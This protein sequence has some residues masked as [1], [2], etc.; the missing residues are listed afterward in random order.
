M[1]GPW[2][3]MMV[4]RRIWSLPSEK[5]RS[6]EKQ[7]SKSWT[8]EDV[9]EMREQSALGVYN[10]REP[11]ARTGGGHQGKFPADRAY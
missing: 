9:L 2:V 6:S 1:L 4:M 8:E 5:S 11:L 3:Y 7:T 10:R